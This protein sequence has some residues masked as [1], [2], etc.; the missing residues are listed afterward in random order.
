[1]SP[2]LRNDSGTRDGLDADIL[3]PLCHPAL[4]SLFSLAECR[5]KL[6]AWWRRVPFAGCVI[7]ESRLPNRAGVR[8]FLERHDGRMLLRT[9]AEMHG[10]REWSCRVGSERAMIRANPA[11]TQRS[12]IRHC[13]RQL[14]FAKEHC[15][16]PSPARDTLHVVCQAVRR[17]PTGASH[18]VRTGQQLDKPSPQAAMIGRLVEQI[19]LEVYIALLPLPTAQLLMWMNRNCR[20]MHAYP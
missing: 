6:S 5:G 10:Q 3:V 4:Y 7:G 16:V 1:M 18:R 9:K 8:L 14:H 17:V 2:P 11:F 13:Q 19:W 12:H 20:S 15:L